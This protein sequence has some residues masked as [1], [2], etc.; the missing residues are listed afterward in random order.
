MSS[1]DCIRQILTDLGAIKQSQA[2]IKEQQV[3][4]T[5]FVQELVRVHQ[6][7]ID[8]KYDVLTEKVDGLSS[9][10]DK[11][12]GMLVLLGL[13]AGGAGWLLTHTIPDWAKDA[14]GAFLKNITR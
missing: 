2:D 5:M 6:E 3:K 7:D 1:E 13:F 11:A 10:R 12:K 9:D 8:S 14:A 4:H